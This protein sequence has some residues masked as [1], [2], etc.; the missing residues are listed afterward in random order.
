M[1]KNLDQEHGYLVK[2]PWEIMKIDYWL[3]HQKRVQQIPKI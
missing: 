1:G 3:D 2:Y